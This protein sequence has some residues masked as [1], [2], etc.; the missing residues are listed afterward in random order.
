MRLQHMTR[1][2][3][4]LWSP[5][6]WFLE[7]LEPQSNF[8]GTGTRASAGHNGLNPERWCVDALGLSRPWHPTGMGLFFPNTT[9]LP[10]SRTQEPFFFYQL[11]NLCEQNQNRK[12]SQREPGVPNSSACLFQHTQ[13]HEPL[14]QELGWCYHHPVMKEGPESAHRGLSLMAVPRQ[15][16]GGLSAT[17][18]P[19]SHCLPAAPPS[20]SS[21]QGQQ[22]SFQN[23]FFSYFCGF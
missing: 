7:S 10:S 12:Q 6:V 8:P 13:P 3:A 1:H 19:P 14:P 5:G 2:L 9:P 17:A 20:L 23:Y 16:S 18:P 15:R 21:A 22:C 11:I 4:L